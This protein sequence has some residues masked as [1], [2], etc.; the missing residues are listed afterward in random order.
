MSRSNQTSVD[1][2][3]T[4][5]KDAQ[6][7][8]WQFGILLGLIWPPGLLIIGVGA[9]YFFN[10]FEGALGRLYFGGILLLLGA[11]TAWITFRTLKKYHIQLLEEFQARP[12][13]SGVDLTQ[14][15]A[16]IPGGSKEGS[17]TGDRA[18]SKERAETENKRPLADQIISTIDS[19]IL[20]LNQNGEIVF[21]SSSVYKI[22]GYQWDEATPKS[23]LEL[24][25]E[26]HQNGPNDAPDFFSSPYEC[27]VL[28]KQGNLYWFLW[29][30]TR[31]LDNCIIRVGYDITQRKNAEAEFTRRNRELTILQSAGVAITS[32][33]DLRYVLDTVALE[34]TKLL[35]VES[36]TISEWN[37]TDNTVVKIAKYNPQGWWDAQ[38]E[39]TPYHLTEYPV[40]RAVLEEQIPEQMTISQANI[41]PSELAY[42][43]TANIKTL[44]MLPMIFQRQVLGLVELEDSRFERTFSYHEISMAK[45]L[46]SQAGSAIENARLFEQARQEIKERQQAEAAL[47]EERALLA[48]RVKER[49]A[50]LSRVN[51]ELARASRLKDEFLAGM[52]HELRTP[53]NA[54]LGSSEILQAG[55]FGSL[56][57]RQ[58]K[59][60]KNIEESGRH[61]LSL[62]N[63]ILDLSKIEAGKMELEI[64]PVAIQSVCEASLRLVKQ[65]AHKKKLQLKSSFSTNNK[66]LRADERRLKQILVNLLS[67]AI[68][69]TPEGGS[70]GLEVEDDEAQ[71]AIHFTVWDTGIGISQEDMTRLF[72][73][74]VQLDSSLARQYAGTGLGLSLVSRMTKMHGGGVS[75]ESQVGQGSRFKIALPY[76]GPNIPSGAELEQVEA[77]RPQRLPHRLRAGSRRPVI[78]LADDSED[79][80]NML[81]EFLQAQGYEIV[82]ARTGIEA[83]DRA[84]EETP[85]LILM[86]IQMPELDGLEATRR[87]RAYDKLA[88]V[89]I[90]ALTALAMPGDK[91]RC[92]QAGAN[93]Y[94]TKPVSPIGLIKTIE[95]FLTPGSS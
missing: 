7:L 18:E 66:I 79:N 37:E 31:G 90:I 89:P 60:T 49:T 43:K 25:G 81:L 84:K 88:L 75:V 38:S 78:L 71:Q 4:P 3:F 76:S 27:R 55:A 46:A 65:L 54:I 6:N 80:I 77:D 1:S 93:E 42:M 41:D 10:S 57:E 13:G 33:L 83:I 23:W 47:E 82:V 53:L 2:K 61:L 36:C 68:K 19:L 35:E 56:N 51:A 48:Q 32:R 5:S 64:R 21:T 40:T 17:D 86:D 94:L 92:L 15:A 22:L 69:F 14:P 26:N 62:I 59:Y 24:V 63:D 28:D 20:V 95:T 52:S 34:M 87:L 74:F 12:Q 9:G 39:A 72:Q 45:L 73:P 29:Q 58:L 91:E 30:D 67:N 44:V 11:G 85:D 16:N 8:K 70:V 50:E